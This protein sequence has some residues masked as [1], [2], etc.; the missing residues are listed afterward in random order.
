MRRAGL[1]E[2]AGNAPLECLHGVSTG[3]D[4]KQLPD[5]AAMVAEAS[6][7]GVPLGKAIVGRDVF[8]HELGVHVAGLLADPKTYSGPNPVLFGRRHRFV[9]GK[10]S[11]AKGLA[12]ALGERGVEL[13]PETAP[14]LIALVRRRATQ[15]KSAISGDELERL[16]E[17]PPPRPRLRGCTRPAEAGGE[18]QMTHS[19]GERPI[20]ET[21]ILD[22]LERLSAAE[23]FFAVLDVLYDEARLRVA[24]LHILKRMGEYLKGDDLA[25]LPEPVAAARAG[26]AATRLRR[27]RAILAARRALLPRA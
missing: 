16:H 23:D 19:R 5:L 11:G 27:L 21:S 8:A 13:A 7:R 15:R 14:F 4:L 22:K 24:R 1:G 2:R 17:E 6:R 20:D 18:F 3:V 10:H 9:V 26:D 25:G 12:H